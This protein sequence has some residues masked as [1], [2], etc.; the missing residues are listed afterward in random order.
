[1]LKSIL[2]AHFEE[3]EKPQESLM[4][5]DGATGLA[6]PRGAQ[7]LPACPPKATFE[8]PYPVTFL[9]AE[10]RLGVRESLGQRRC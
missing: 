1:M 2:K 7:L 9:Q 10:G 8:P 4:P 3:E 5:E 6:S